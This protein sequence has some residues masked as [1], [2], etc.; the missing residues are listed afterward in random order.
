MISSEYHWVPVLS[1]YGSIVL[2][3]FSL[4]LFL[5]AFSSDISSFQTVFCPSCLKK[6]CLKKLSRESLR[7][8]F[9]CTSGVLGRF[10]S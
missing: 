4:E 6:L 1:Y 8:C 7:I 3:H 5:F 2:L 9:T 10:P